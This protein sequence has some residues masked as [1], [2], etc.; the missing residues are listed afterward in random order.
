MGAIERC[1]FK[2]IY[3]KS[4]FLKNNNNNN[5]NNNIEI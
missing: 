1:F 4:F 2:F 5:N 3:F